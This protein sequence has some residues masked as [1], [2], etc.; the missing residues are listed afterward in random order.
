MAA[1][2]Q[3]ML[4]K[5]ACK[6]LLQ[7][8]V[9]STTGVYNILRNVSQDLFPSG[10][11]WRWVHLCQVCCMHRQLSSLKSWIKACANLY[12]V[13]GNRKARLLHAHPNLL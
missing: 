2:S 5:K 6:L 3:E 13:L 10:M 4:G 7:R 1:S 9:C 11:V 12:Y 8:A